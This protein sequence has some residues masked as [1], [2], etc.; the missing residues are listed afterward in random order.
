VGDGQKD[1][2]FT[3]DRAGDATR[4]TDLEWFK[5]IK[6]R[7]SY[8]TEGLVKYTLNPWIR[9]L[10]IIMVLCI[11]MVLFILMV[12]CILRVLCTGR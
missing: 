4:Y 11:L 12:L 3:V 8:N 9:Y 1:N 2:Y 10:C 7:W 5:D 6:R